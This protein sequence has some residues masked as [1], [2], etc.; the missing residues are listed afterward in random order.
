MKALL[1]TLCLAASACGVASANDSGHSAIVDMPKVAT[2]TQN[3][4]TPGMLSHQF[5]QMT[6][7]HQML[8]L[9]KDTHL[10]TSRNSTDRV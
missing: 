1:L 6:G 7:Q 8:M 2:L 3:H 10:M 5:S 9:A 4:L